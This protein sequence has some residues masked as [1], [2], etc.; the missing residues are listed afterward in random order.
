MDPISLAGLGIGAASLAFELFAGCIKG[1]VLLSTAHNMGKDS[2]TLLCMLNLQEIQLTD[3]ARRAGLLSDSRT[4]D[5]RLNETV[6]HAVLQELK[7][8]LLDTEKLKSRYRLGLTNHAPKDTNVQSPP[9]QGILS[10]AISWE[11]RNDILLT[12][13]LVQ[14]RNHFPRRLWWAA[15][16][17]SKFE[18]YI[19][20]IRFFVQ[21][22]WRLLDPLRQDEMAAGLQM[23]LSHVIGMSNKLGDLKSLQDALSQASNT[24]TEA[25]DKSPYSTLE[26]VAEIKAITLTINSASDEHT[27]LGSLTNI[28]RNQGSVR[29][30]YL[31]PHLLRD[32]VALKSNPGMGVARYDDKTVF[33]EWKSLPVDR[34]HKVM[35]MVEDLA[36]LLSA[37]KHPSFRSL[38]C[39]G[40]ARYMEDS[41]AAFV[42]ELPDIDETQPPRPLRTLFGSISPSV[43]ERLHLALQI[44][45][46]VRHFH[47]AG[48][49]H[50][51]LRSQNILVLPSGDQSTS[52]IFPLTRPMLAGFAYSRV[53]AS[54]EVSERPSA[55]PQCDIYRHPDAMG[56]PS[57]SFTAEK[58]IYA[59]G[60]VL[61]EI[62]ETEWTINGRCTGKS[63][64]PLT[65][66]GIKQVQRTR[67]ILVGT[68]KLIDPARFCH[69][70]SSPRQRAQQTLDMLLGEAQ[71]E[72]LVKDG[73]LTVTEDIGE[74][75]Y[76]DYEGVVPKEIRSRRKE[77][78]L[79]TERAWDIWVDGCEGGESPEQ[80]KERLDDL[81]QKT[82][83]LQKP[84]MH[85][86]TAGDVLV[87]AH[88]QILRAF[89]KRWLKYSMDF[90]LAMMMEPGAI[91]ILSYA[92]HNIEEPS[93]LIGMG[94]P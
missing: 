15:V 50:K 34:R 7:N 23:V 86:G 65:P 94:F 68:G 13:R 3:W 87:V 64:I 45:E 33:I 53:E 20:Q 58:D 35:A 10:S 57:M 79:D 60:T 31:A 9:G 83:E 78:G 28:D 12:A 22:L 80:V 24:R 19:S 52:G 17:K 69:V 71:R 56:D 8:L 4:L 14:S 61:L 11:T 92:H 70:F 74:W 44:T 43:T 62:G 36:L 49:L 39:Q 26:S 54:P 66:N 55:D 93:I 91:G 38:R 42:F 51:D 41:K 63:E 67:D 84:H 82:T 88:G 29:S 37:P 21:E 59:L 77:R 76:G 72:A 16:D 32:F 1:F 27:S 18:E 48:W 89:T 73:K 30:L 81:I 47:T 25:T 40:L 2:S 90:P 6:V 85:G 75:D 46:S 5:R